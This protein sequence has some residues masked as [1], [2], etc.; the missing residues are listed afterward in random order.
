M[1]RVHGPSRRRAIITGF[2][3]GAVSTGDDQGGFSIPWTAAHL[4]NFGYSADVGGTAGGPTGVQLNR[5][6][7]ESDTE[8]M[9]STL[10]LA[11]DASPVN[12]ET[13]AFQNNDLQKGDIVRLDVDAAAT[14]LAGLFWWAEV[15]VEQY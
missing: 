11:H 12:S 5:V 4:V 3:S 13:D 10:T 2:I 9:A 7:N 8:L 14:N 6:R 15:H 1:G